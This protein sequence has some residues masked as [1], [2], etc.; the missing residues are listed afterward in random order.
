[1]SV[2]CPDGYGAGCW[3]VTLG[4]EHGVTVA[5]EA[6]FWTFGEDKGGAEAYLRECTALGVVFADALDA[7]WAGLD[8]TIAAALAAF[9]RGVWGPRR[10]GHDIPRAMLTPD[11]L[12]DAQGAKVAGP[13]RDG[14]RVTSD[15]I[16]MAQALPC[17]VGY[18]G[19]CNG[20]RRE[21]ERGDRLDREVEAEAQAWCDDKLKALGWALA[22]K[23]VKGV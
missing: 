4:H 13:W 11:A 8:A 9:E 19:H 21:F 22:N 20:L 1:V 3:T 17:G 5:Q 23:E 18:D 12:W 14:E 16:C 7:D 10:D 2:T 15:G 6:C